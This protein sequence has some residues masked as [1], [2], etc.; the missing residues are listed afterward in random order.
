MAWWKADVLVTGF[1]MLKKIPSNPKLPVL[2]TALDGN[3][4][5]VAASKDRSHDM[6]GDPAVTSERA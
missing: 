4:A 3:E 5:Q 1:S 6:M 2:P